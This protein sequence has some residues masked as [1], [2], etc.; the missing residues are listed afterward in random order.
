MLNGRYDLAT[1]LESSAKPMFHFLGT[2]EPD[3]VHRIYD[4][5]H[6]IEKKELIRESLDWLDT[7]LGPVER[8]TP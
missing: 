1:P 5:D 7:Y 8:A 6:W 3:K 2:A 4:T